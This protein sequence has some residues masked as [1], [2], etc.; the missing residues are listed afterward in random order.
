MKRTK[1]S[2]IREEYKKSFDYLKGSKNFIYI[3][4]GIFFAFCLIGFLVPAPDFISKGIEEIIKN[5]LTE[6]EGL[7]IRGLIRF[8]F[9]NNLQ[10][11]FFGMIFGVLFGI[12]PVVFAVVNGYLLGFVSSV[13]VAEE[14][15]FVLWRLLPHG[16]FELPAIFISLGLGL[17]FG[18]FVF[19][20]NIGE[21][22]REYLWSSLR[23]FLFVVFPLLI[24][25]AIIEGS[26][27]ALTG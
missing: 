26:L 18:T 1:K 24:V 6:T 16:V 7:S 14:G 20:K 3:I 19:Q 25:A 11:S 10:S 22:F 2:F 5:I 12:L 27:I 8:I 23:V 21:S 4:T 15:F 9:F 17:K 13:V